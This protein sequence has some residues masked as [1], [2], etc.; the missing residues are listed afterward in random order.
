[1]QRLPHSAGVA[2]QQRL[3]R[4]LIP[5]YR[6]ATERFIA[7][8]GHEM[9][10]PARRGR[11][12][13]RQMMGSTANAAPKSYLRCYLAARKIQRRRVNVGLPLRTLQYGRELVGCCRPHHG[14]RTHTRWNAMNRF[15]CSVRRYLPLLLLIAAMPHPAYAACPKSVRNR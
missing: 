13:D 14:Q 12:S 10:L 2:A 8:R 5:S 6:A 11:A 1:M 4:V 9:R 15:M 7:E 3:E